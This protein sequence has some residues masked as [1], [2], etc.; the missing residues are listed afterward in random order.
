ML[1]K[2]VRPY[3]G[4]LAVYQLKI[5]AMSKASPCIEQHVVS[6]LLRHSEIKHVF[7]KYWTAQQPSWFRV[8]LL[9]GFNVHSATARE[10]G[11]SFCGV[12]RSQRACRQNHGQP[13]RVIGNVAGLE[14]CLCRGGTGATPDDDQTERIDSLSTVA[15]STR[16][17]MDVLEAWI[18]LYDNGDVMVSVVQY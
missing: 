8:R 10:K 15:S 3:A 13:K 17:I 18:S 14:Q 1:Y 5:C 9:L 16:T 7:A 11:R 4:F 12:R 6:T 2:R